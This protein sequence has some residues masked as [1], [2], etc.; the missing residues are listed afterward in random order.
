MRAILDTIS[1]IDDSSKKILFKHFD[2]S[3][4]NHLRTKAP[5]LKSQLSNLADETQN[6]KFHSDV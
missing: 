2:Q 5:D 3:T 4:V 1:S 6:T